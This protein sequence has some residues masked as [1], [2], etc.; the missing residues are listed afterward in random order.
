MRSTIL[1]TSLVTLAGLSIWE[2]QGNAQQTQ[3][4]KKASAAKKSVAKKS[5]NVG[6]IVPQ[7]IILQPDTPIVITDGSSI[8]FQK[9]TG[10]TFSPSLVTVQ[11][12]TSQGAALRVYG[13]V[14]NPM[15]AGCT[16]HVIPL[17]DGSTAWTVT[18]HHT[19]DTQVITLHFPSTSDSGSV[20]ISIPAAVQRQAKFVQVSGSAGQHVYESFFHLGYAMVNGHKLGCPAPPAG[21][22]AGSTACE[23]EIVPN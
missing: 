5:G 10:F 15:P 8:H 2:L 11:I 23:M 6:K 13:C 1:L 9:D 7:Y 17:G 20:D 21:T 18:L 12:D 14:G 22:P 16:G 19:D 3:E 4:A